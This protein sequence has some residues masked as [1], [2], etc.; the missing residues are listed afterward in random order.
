M[1]NHYQ[2]KKEIKGLSVCDLSHTHKSE[3]TDENGS[4]P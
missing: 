3:N 4:A 2:K 1:T